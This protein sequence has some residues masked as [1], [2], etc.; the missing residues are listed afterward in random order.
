MI[1]L[2]KIIIGVAKLALTMGIKEFELSRRGVW[3]KAFF[4]AAK[5]LRPSLSD[6]AAATYAGVHH[7]IPLAE[8]PAETE[9]QYASAVLERWRRNK[10]YQN[11]DGPAPLPVTG[12]N[13]ATFKSLVQ[14]SLGDRVGYKNVLTELIEAGCVTVNNSTVFLINPHLVGPF[15]PAVINGFVTG[16]AAHLDSIIANKNGPVYPEKTVWS[17]NVDASRIPE[18]NKEI[19]SLSRDYQENVLSLIEKFESDNG[20]AIVIAGMYMYTHPIPWAE[21]DHAELIVPQRNDS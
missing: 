6:A 1:M 18:L 21:P 10:S 11:A 17:T 9:P 19:S 16:I 5:R 20:Q 3:K 15:S 12:S 14:D 7:K 13:R 2:E 4:V 8:T